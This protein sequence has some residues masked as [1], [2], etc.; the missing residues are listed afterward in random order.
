MKKATAEWNYG[1]DLNPDVL[2]D[3]RE[4]TRL[5]VENMS[6][7]ELFDEEGTTQDSDIASEVFIEHMDIREPISVLRWA[8]RQSAA[9]NSY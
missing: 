6:E 1:T 4:S 9:M 7:H 2:Q 3:W 5:Q 8:P